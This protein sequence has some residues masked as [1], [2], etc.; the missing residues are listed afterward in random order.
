MLMG[1]LRQFTAAA[2]ATGMA[3][4][5]G[6]ISVA[7]YSPSEGSRALRTDARER[8]TTR[9][10]ACARSAVVGKLPLVPAPILSCPGH[11]PVSWVQGQ[12]IGHPGL[13]EGERMSEQR[14]GEQLTQA[15][16]LMVRHGVSLT[17][18]DAGPDGPGHYEARLSGQLVAA[19]VSLASLV[20]LLHRAL[21]GRRGRQWARE[22]PGRR[23]SL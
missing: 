4:G 16:E 1:G 18:I 7:R 21:D 11:L 10:L 14:L 19:A 12:V 15:R 6:D 8:I 23:P 5:I 3:F 22:G 13:P 9:R 17:F 2:L 20:S